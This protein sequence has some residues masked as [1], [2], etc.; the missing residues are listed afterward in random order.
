MEQGLDVRTTKVL[1]DCL[2]RAFLRGI[3]VEKSECQDLSQELF[4]HV[5]EKRSLFDPQKA[6]PR[7]FIRR[8][9][10]TRLLNWQRDRLRQ[11]RDPR[12][13]IPYAP[14]Q[15]PDDYLE[16][17]EPSL[18]SLD[19][20]DLMV[21]GD[22]D[23]IERREGLKVDVQLALSSLP[24]ADQQLCLALIQYSKSEAA[25]LL[26]L[27]RSALYRRIEGIREHFEHW[28]LKNYLREVGQF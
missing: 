8:I 18:G 5:W 28:G 12:L 16:D 10:R 22:S 1:C 23:T 15:G 21:G 11:C 24:L 26:G 20:V 17:D 14:E 25:T 9:C 27:S 3:P 13:E 6:N 19:F 4:L 2:A 7:T